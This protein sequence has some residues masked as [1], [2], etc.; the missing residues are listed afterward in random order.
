MSRGGSASEADRS[1][2]GASGNSRPFP[3]SV[4]VKQGGDDGGS[5]STAVVK[6]DLEVKRSNQT[7]RQGCSSLAGCSHVTVFNLFSSVVSR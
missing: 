3:F 1:S 7:L 5:A 4:V 6:S 2:E